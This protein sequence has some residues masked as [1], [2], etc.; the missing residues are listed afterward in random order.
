MVETLRVL[1]ALLAAVSLAAVLLG[2]AGV[3]TW[4]VEQRLGTLAPGGVVFDTLA[5]NP[6]TGRLALERVRAR[7]STGREIFRADEVSATAPVAD[8]L[9]GVVTLQRVQVGSPRLVVPAGPVLELIGLG[10]EA[11]RAPPI[12]VNGLVL[13]DGA[14]VIEDVARGGP[15]VVRDLAVRADRMSALGGE[16][17]FAVEMAVYGARV[18]LAGQRAL[19]APGYAVHVRASGLEAVA[20]LRDF[21]MLTAGRGFTLVR[22]RADVDGTLLFAEQGV[23][24]SGRARLERVL[25]RF[26]DR[27]LSPFSAAAVILGVDRWDVAAGAGRIARL[28][29]RAPR[30]SISL[31]RA[32]PPLLTSVLGVFADDGIVLRRV[33]I[34]DG[35]LTLDSQSG[36]VSLRGLNVALQAHERLAGS[37]FVLT[38]R[39]GVGPDGRL[40]VEGAL[41]R[42]LRRAEGALRAG[43]VRAGTCT[44]SDVTVPLPAE[45]T[46]ESL[47]AALAATCTADAAVPDIGRRTK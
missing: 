9:A 13:T 24:A 18:R 2:G 16:G 43:G 28:E 6:F 8:L 38:G 45:P 47:V 4:L 7:D 19:G 27:R 37:G 34:V 40:A 30:L 11:P 17:A 3:A 15:L 12:T 36:P 46:L 41:S 10:G 42:D 26:G 39:A 33:R 1:P 44:V 5:Y 25:A 22:G 14:L 32:I 23:L 29:V 35:S 20:A 31:R 21:P